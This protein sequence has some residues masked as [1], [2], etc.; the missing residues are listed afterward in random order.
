M[1]HDFGTVNNNWT[2]A[3]TYTVP[4]DKRSGL[5]SVN[6]AWFLG[7]ISYLFFDGVQV[8][9]ATTTAAT[10]IAYYQISATGSQGFHYF[11][12]G[13]G[14]YSVCDGNQINF[15]DGLFGHQL[16]AAEALTLYEAFFTIQLPKVSGYA[17]ECLLQGVKAFHIFNEGEPT[18][19]HYEYFSPPL[20]NYATKNTG[21]PNQGHGLAM[22]PYGTVVVGRPSPIPGQTAASFKTGAYVGVGGL[23]AHSRF[24]HYEFIIQRTVT[25]AP[26]GTETIMEYRYNQNGAYSTVERKI[27]LGTNRRF[28]FF[29]RGAVND[30]ISPLYVLPDNTWVKVY[31]HCIRT[32]NRWDLYINDVWVE[33][34]VCG[35][36]VDLHG[37]NSQTGIT[38]AHQI[39]GLVNNSLVV[40]ERFQGDIASFAIFDFYDAHN[41]ARMIDFREKRALALTVL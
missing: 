27:S 23:S 37:T 24:V 30:T 33:T 7:G 26:G 35:A 41:S 25:T 13:K 40:S 1:P 22:T 32:S 4:V 5:H 17:K 16:T 21:Y 38:M 8:A 6:I 3:F 28:T 29:A 31:F 19:V 36:N 12:H 39:G 20:A 34:G 9:S 15:A 11:L 2:T 10:N 18:D 14:D